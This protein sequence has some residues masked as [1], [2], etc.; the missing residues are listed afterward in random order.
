[1]RT[2]TRGLGILVACTLLGCS[3]DT[4][5]F[6]T[7]QGGAGQG[8]AGQG[9]AGAG[10]STGA[11]SSGGAGNS[12]N[13]GGLNLG[14]NGGAGGIDAC[15]ATSAEATLLVKPVDVIFVIDNS[16]SMG[17]NIQSV[18]NNI[19]DSFAAIIGASGIDYRV[20][21]ISMHGNLGSESICVGAP[22]STTD[23]N[24]VPA[25]PGE[26]P[27]IFYQYSV[28]IGSHDSV[29]RAF[30]SY[31]GTLAD[32][33]GLA[34]GGW[35][36]WL[37]E[38]AFKVFVEVTDDGTTCTFDGQNFDDNDNEPD[39]LTAAAAIDATLLALDPVQFGNVNKRNYMW[40]SIV[41]LAEAAVPT[42]AYG[43]AEPIVVGE[44]STAVAPGSAYQALSVLT[45]GLRFPICQ[46]ASFDVVF[47][48]IATGIV[49]GALVAC[50]FAIPE[51]P[52]GETI[53]LDT[54]VL[55]YTPGGGGAPV[56]MAQ[57]ADLAACVPSAFYIEGDLIKLCPDAC[58]V[59]QADDAASVN[60]LF[61][62]EQDVN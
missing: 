10:S 2:M 30:S 47:Q 11:S 38:D 39:G 7:S 26:N 49:E 5:T 24:P 25:Q 50:E 29:C 53:D 56:N 44:C 48:E 8:G 40:H 57:V 20:I 16:G 46:F 41:G 33:F 55:E 4:S 37:R 13:G 36:Q 32:S 6:Q 18:Q 28:E 54:V 23:C 12:G 35:S 21:M 27:P 45:G 3:E 42:D 52:P 1:M 14:G 17:D 51:P 62:C 19:N 58:A 15:V 34:P 9:G 61:G 60:V 43:P 59:V 22:L 31:D